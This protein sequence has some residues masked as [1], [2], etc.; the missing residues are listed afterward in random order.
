[1]CCFRS[2]VRSFG[3]RSTRLYRVP[4][5]SS[6]CS[7]HCYTKRPCTGLSDRRRRYTCHAHSRVPLRAVPLCRTAWCGLNGGL[8]VCERGEAEAQM[9]DRRTEEGTQMP[10]LGISLLCYRAAAANERTNERMRQPSSSAAIHSTPPLSLLYNTKYNAAACH[11]CL[12]CWL[13]QLSSQRSRGIRRRRQKP[14]IIIYF[15]GKGSTLHFVVRMRW[16]EG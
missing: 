6:F 13:L 3:C 1:M 4:S 15:V 9:N 7:G 16:F 8:T 10:C 5:V 12:R 14:S 11:C 2:V